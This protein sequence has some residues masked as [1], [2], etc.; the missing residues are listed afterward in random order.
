[1]KRGWSEVVL[2]ELLRPRSESSVISPAGQYQ[3]VTVSLWGKGV[4]LR[5]K[6]AGSEIASAERN[7]AREG[8]F[9]VS[10]IDAR[11]GA[12]GFIPKELDGAVVTNDFPLFAIVTEKIHPRW[13][14]WVTR[15]HFFVELCRAA[16]EGT[17]NRVRLKESKFGQM[18]VPLPP[19]A[20]QQRIVAHLDAIE[21]RLMRAKKLR[22]E[23]QKEKLAF[24]TSMAHRWDLT[25]DAKRKR[26]WQE[27]ELGEV[28]RLA[29]DVVEVDSTASYPN[30]GIYSY[31]RGTFTKPPIDGS[32]TSAAQLYRVRSGQ[33]IYSRLFAFEGAYAFVEPSQDGYYVSNEFPVF[34]LNAERILPEFLFAYF[35]SPAV[36]TQLAEQSIGLGN[37]RQR[38]HPEVILDHRIH[39]PPPDYQRHVSAVFRK[40]INSGTSNNDVELNALLPSLLD[41]IFNP[42]ARMADTRTSLNLC[43]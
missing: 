29:S 27:C 7:V 19:L 12:Y 6:V 21:A 17:T 1:M 24:L 30:L 32:T 33:F 3:E 25:G 28:L 18:A 41:R 10:K 35:K 34:D 42:S 11:H 16:S 15:S 5:R 43:L 20:E 36:W 39:I 4:R 8:D 40:V 23:E 26:G 13:L 14:Y 2:G 22:E 38:I 9:I 37:R 31:G